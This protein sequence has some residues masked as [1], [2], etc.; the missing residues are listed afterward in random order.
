MSHVHR[1]NKVNQFASW[2]HRQIYIICDVVIVLFLKRFLLDKPPQLSMLLR[3]GIDNS[4]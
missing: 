2:S 1:E 4:F 3:Q